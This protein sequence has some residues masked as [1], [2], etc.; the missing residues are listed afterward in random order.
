MRV[1]LAVSDPD[2]KIA[3]PLAT[4]TRQGRDRDAAYF[5]AL[6]RAEGIVGLVIGCRCI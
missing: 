2:R 4:Y 1:G 5:R 6:V 3:F